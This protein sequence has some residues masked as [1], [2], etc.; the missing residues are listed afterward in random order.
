MIGLAWPWAL[1]LLPLP[2]LL[3][4][5]LSRAPARAP[6]L[7]VPFFDCYRQS[8]SG[9][10]AV[11]A[12]TRPLA[13]ACWLLLVLAAA[14]PQWSGEPLPM[15]LSGRDLMLAVDISGSMERP[16]LDQAGHQLTRLAA[17]KQVAREFI[18]QR[19]GDRVGLILF[20][21]RAYLQTPLTFDRQTVNTL[22]GEAQIGLAGKETAIGDAIG[23]AIQ[24]LGSNAGPSAA[25]AH[26]S[27]MGDLWGVGSPRV[28][29]LLTDG[30]NTAGDLD[31]LLAAR[32][33]GQ[34]GIRI[35]T[36]GIGAAARPA[37]GPR[38]GVGPTSDLDETLLRDI[39]R[40]SGGLFFRAPDV[41]GLEQVYAQLDR[42]EPVVS[43][44]RDR[45]SIASLYHWPLG[46][47][48]L[49]SVLVAVRLR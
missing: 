41:A 28:L 20:G 14:R 16:D 21:S 25:Y 11:S 48:L 33:A 10:R 2:V 42:I 22:L 43:E 4:A 6:A 12:G 1:L 35:H 44:Y 32:F 15:P 37:P 23:L 8:A 9:Q 26:K 29:V 30:S 27:L 19:Y 45:R 5:W 3:R 34:V 46:I 40:V 17:V 18:G 7:R 13:A 31:P 24:R 38:G 49:L 36:V 47:A 39:A